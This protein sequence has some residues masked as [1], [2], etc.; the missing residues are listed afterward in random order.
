MSEKQNIEYKE[1]WR[2]DY[3]KAIC[4]FANS[5]GG[6]LY[7]GIDDKGKKIGI[8]QH[9]KLMDDLP[10]KIRNHLGITSEVN[11][12][13][14]KSIYTIEIVVP[15]SSVAISYHSRYYTRSGSIT[16]ELSGSSL[17]DFLLKKSGKTWDDVFEDRATLKDIDNNTISVFLDAAKKSGRLPNSDG[18]NTNELLE[19]LRLA[20]GKKLKRAAIILFGKDPGKFYPN[21]SVKIGRFSSENDDIQFQEVEEGNLLHLLNEVKLQLIEN[22]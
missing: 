16:T 8:A 7:L 22:F 12:K 9:K 15:L 11:L 13:K 14:S 3:L 4:A 17:S 6:K 1:K 19:K 20:D 5:Q 18:L 21:I 2:D 10:N